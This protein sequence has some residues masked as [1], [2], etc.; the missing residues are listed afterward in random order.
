MDQTIYEDLLEI[1]AYLESDEER[2]FEENDRPER[3]IYRN[4]MR[5]RAWVNLNAPSA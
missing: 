2:H 1:L 3:H 5:V 4:V